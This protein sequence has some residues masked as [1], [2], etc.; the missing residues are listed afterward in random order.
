MKRLILLLFFLFLYHL[1]YPQSFDLL[2]DYQ[3][4]Q[5]IIYQFNRNA[6]PADPFW[7]DTASIINI[8]NGTYRTYIDSITFNVYDS[9]NTYHLQIHKAG[10]E[11]IRNVN[12]IISSENVDTIY[13]SSIFEFVNDNFGSS[14]HRIKG[15]L[16][17]DTVNQSPRCPWDTTIFNPYSYYYRFYH[18]PSTDTFD[19]IKDTLLLSNLTTDCYDFGY[20]INFIV[21]INDGLLKRINGLFNFFDWSYTDVFTKDEVSGANIE[22]LPP[23]QFILFQNYPN[24]FNPITTIKYSVPKTSNVNLTVY[25]V[26]GKEIITLVN[27]E[28]IQGTYEVQFNGK[29]TSSGVYFY[30]MK[31][32]NFI[33]TK[34]LILLK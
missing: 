26:L 17:P 19:I 15:W 25:N 1:I 34:K 23:E 31:A 32:G 3:P 12:R 20:T 18:F 21:T 8:F 10:I 24:P 28:K 2:K 16:F 29:N 11:I 14:G 13:A 4:G 5:S 33:G 30:V 27:E 7:Q 6:S 22:T 9:I